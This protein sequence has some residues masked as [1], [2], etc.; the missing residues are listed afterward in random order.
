MSNTATNILP[1]VSLDKLVKAYVKIRD[2]RSEIKKA[3]DAEDTVL[4]DQLDAVRAALLAHCKEHGVDSVRTAEGLFYR[5]V[6]Q[7]YWTS[8]WEQMHKFILEHEEPSL[9]DK[10][11]N[12]KH[13]REFLEDN[14]DLLPKGLNSNSTYTISVRK[15]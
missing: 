7:T 1:D 2:H 13:M 14:P 8:D 3:Y 6:K 11:I 12:Q 4:V 15:K 5:T 10:R 9:L